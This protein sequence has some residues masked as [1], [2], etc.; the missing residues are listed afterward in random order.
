MIFYHNL[1]WEKLFLEINF[2]IVLIFYLFFFAYLNISK[3]D[4]KG[5]N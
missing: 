5:Q 3:S 2:C 1:F 4:K